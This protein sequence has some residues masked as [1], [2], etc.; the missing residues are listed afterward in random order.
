MTIQFQISVGHTLAVIFSLLALC[1]VGFLVLTIFSALSWKRVAHPPATFTPP[2]SILKSLRGTDRG[3]Y[4]AFRS[5]CLQDYP[6]FEL[7][8]G[9]SDPHDAAITD[10][11]RLQ[12]EFP[13]RRIALVQC[14]QQLGANGKVSTLAQMLPH[15]SYAFVLI[16]D[17]DIRV[18]PDYLHRI[19]AEFSDQSVGLVTALYRAEA[20][21]SLASRIEA[22]T[23]ATDFAAGVLS[24]RV[25][26]G[27]IH[28]ALGSTIAIR[29][30]VLDK[31]G[32]LAPLVDYLAD[33]YELGART[34]AAGFKVALADTV[35]ETQLPSYG[36]QG[37]IAHQ[38]RWART[39]RDRRLAGYIGLAFTFGLPWALLAFA[40][41][42][43]ALTVT[44]LASIFVLRMIAAWMLCS[45]ILH[46]LKT[47]RDLWLVPLRDLI[48]L[49]IWMVSFAGSTVVWRG[50][51][52][53]VKDGRLSHR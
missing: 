14:S 42:P 21:D 37:M 20:G 4:E 12:R 7:I 18:E 35:V 9:V 25:V 28:F 32:G 26:E 48:G 39:I 16:N 40:A 23:I 15:A 53:T 5:H 41:A 43:S 29:R 3:M 47:T 11:E 52:F 2:I 10:V 33:D 24:A 19:A 46:D 49:Y 34:S 30:D 36:F 51:V 27:G 22:V 38:L 50:E 6:D 17:S 1:G 31:I 44:L 45:T 13:A 8:F